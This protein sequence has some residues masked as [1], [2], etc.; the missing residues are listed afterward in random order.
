ME[1]SAQTPKNTQRPQVGLRMT[2]ELF[3]AATAR[4]NAEGQVLSDWIRAL[5][6]RELGL[7]YTG[8]RKFGG[9]T[10]WARTREELVA[11]AALMRRAKAEKAVREQREI[12]AR[13]SELD[14]VKRRDEDSQEGTAQSA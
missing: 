10:S 3:D 2:R 13:V 6:A 14:A 8:G 9:D 5:V 4:A 1:K 7:P 12:F 11:Q